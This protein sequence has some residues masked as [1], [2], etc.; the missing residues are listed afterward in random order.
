MMMHADKPG[1]SNQDIYNAAYVPA[2]MRLDMTTPYSRGM[3]ELRLSLLETYGGDRDVL[4]VG[5]GPGAFLIPVLDRVKS[6]V[7]LDFS[8]T[9]LDGFREALGGQIPSH[10]TLLEEDVTRLSLPSA[11]VDF[12]FS[13]ASLYYVPRLSEAIIQISRVLRPGGYA[14]LELGNLWSLNTLVAG[15]YHRYA[16]WAKPEHVSVPAMGRMFADAGLN[17][18]TWHCFQI[19][20]MYGLTKSLILLAPV[21]LPAWKT[22]M[23]KRVGGRMLDEWI[24]S[25][26]PL[27][28]FAFRHLVVVRKS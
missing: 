24:S 11:S 25:A 5:C 1:G 3:N 21:C 13:F 23:A 27:R 16:G 26:W 18:V 6:A 7:G 10:L 19:L 22:V 28:Y 14:A 17:P 20:P 8:R 9:M 12:A 4:D 2:Q 15:H